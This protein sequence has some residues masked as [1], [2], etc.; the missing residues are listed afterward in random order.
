MDS[1]QGLRVLVVEDEAPIAMMIEDM[2]EDMGCVVAGSV[3]TVDDALQSVE[4]GGF[5][6][7][8]LD[9]NLCGRNAQAVAD[10]LAAKHIPFAVGS[11][12]GRAGLP[13]HLQNRPVLQK[14]FLGIDLERAIRLGV[15]GRPAESS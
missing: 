15:S 2:L 13:V 5:D 7:V 14:P 4:K 12:Y 1:L 11:G 3:A 9:L 8:L 6:F 10:A